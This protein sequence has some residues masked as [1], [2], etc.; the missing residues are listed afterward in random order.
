M[1]IFIFSII[2]HYNQVF[3]TMPNAAVTIVTSLLLTTLLSRYVSLSQT[4]RKYH[5]VCL[6]TQIYPGTLISDGSCL[7]ATISGRMPP[8]A[9]LIPCEI[10]RWPSISARNLG[11]AEL[12]H[13]LAT[14]LHKKG[15]Y[16][17]AMAFLL[18]D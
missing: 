2:Q 11:N 15:S 8:T 13:S 16:N 18:S 6:G 17:C 3:L 12:Y 5:I 10:S 7:L 4:W 14:C 1:S 9:R